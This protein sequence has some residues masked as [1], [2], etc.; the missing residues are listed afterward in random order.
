M[1]KIDFLTEGLNPK[2]AQAVA[3]PLEY[4]T[5]IVAG[6][7]TGK[8]KIISK[9]FAKLVF[10][11]LTPE[12]ILVITFTDKAAGEMRERIIQEL[13]QN[14]IKSDEKTLWISTF[15][16]FCSKIISENLAQIGIEEKYTLASQGELLEVFGEIIT[17][18]KQNKI[19]EEMIAIAANLGL[20]A[21][22]FELDNLTKLSKIAPLDEL[23]E[24]VFEIIKKIKSYGLSPFEFLQK[25]VS[26]N[27]NYS[28]TIAQLGFGYESKDNY[29]AAWQEVLRPYA[30]AKIDIDE[31]AQPKVVLNKNGSSKAERWCAA[32]GFPEKLP[33]IDQIEKDFT[34][35]VAVIYALY[36]ENLRQKS[37]LDFDD[38]INKT[39]ELL[40][41][42][43]PVRKFYQ[44]KFKHIIIDEFQDTNSS[45]LE[46]IKL[47][48]NE[49]YPNITFVGDRKQSI[50]GFR[51]A[52]MENL[53]SLHEFVERKFAQKFPEIKLEVN[54]RST[55]AV[56]EAVNFVTEKILELDEN[57]QAFQGEQNANYV[58]TTKFCDGKNSSELKMKE[59]EFIAQEILALKQNDS[60]NFK[61]FAVL[62]KSHF[63]A[64]FIERILAKSAIPSIK[65]VNS[66]Y[67]ER[68]LVKDVIALFRLLLKKP[69]E[70]ALVRVLQ[71]KMDEPDLYRFVLELK[72]LEGNLYEKA[73]LLGD[74]PQTLVDIFEFIQANKNLELKEIFNNAKT[75]L[76]ADLYKDIIESNK[77]EIEYKIL[78]M[79][80]DD[81]EKHRNHVSV[82]EFLKFFENLP[83]DS[84]Y[85][86]PNPIGED[87][88]AVNL[89]TVHASKG[90]EFDYVFLLNQSKRSQS[91]DTVAVLDLQYGDKSGFGILINKFEGKLS[92]KMAIYKSIWRA[93][94][95][96]AE[97][98]RLFYVALSRAKKYLNVMT[99][100]EVRLFE[101]LV[102][103]K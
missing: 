4:C 70:M 63:Q 59:A 51:H 85:T 57:L 89:L 84:N 49:D 91:Q 19:D 65:K 29:F 24:S 80:I 54:Y 60:A 6:A 88:D 40:K 69:D 95:E 96:K 33:Q 15:H 37:M 99:F 2:Q 62:V 103:E 45:Q 31:L 77:I 75:F 34:N 82:F 72:E 5:K 22:I 86:L 44:T 102:E 17:A 35:L 47:L 48:I 101:G 64:D 36:Q 78:E 7:G 30:S 11:N 83:T 71:T 42:N 74:K 43:P 10:D 52:Q 18:L 100:D 1:N 21:E 26:A 98:D 27:Q 53:D 39:L 81:F 38:L 55:Q 46:L 92:P 73:E 68:P 23:F 66:G 32:A 61:D 94:R 8:T 14:N 90:L 3:N 25:S 13:D 16:G 87:I 93:P 76:Q 97:K 28:K 20:E 50:Y 41:H 56:I 58:K 9:R 12:Q 67:F 79:I